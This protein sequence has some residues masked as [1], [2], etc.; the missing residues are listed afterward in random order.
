MFKPFFT[1]AALIA[2]LVLLAACGSVVSEPRTT[3]YVETVSADALSM[4][5]SPNSADIVISPIET[6][7]GLMTAQI[8]HLGDLDYSI[9]GQVSWSINLREEA[10]QN[11]NYVGRPMRWNIALNPAAALDLDV[12]SGSG[13]LTLPLSDFSLRGLRANLG[14]GSVNL[15][16][17]PSETPIPISINGGS[18]SAIVT[19]TDGTRVN[20]DA[21]SLSS[22]DFSFS[23]MG[24]A[25]L[26]GRVTLSSGGVTLNFAPGAAGELNV[27]VASGDVDITFPEGMAVRV[28]LRSMASGDVDMGDALRRLSASGVTENTG[29]WETPGFDE[30]ENQLTLVIEMS[31]GDLRVR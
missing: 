28:D 30:A 25:E 4:S 17:P 14:S 1:R 29:T 23:N 11:V 19:A 21:I 27:S 6:G 12:N 20:F 15:T 31:S 13:D 7:D 3:E 24:Q 10:V 22:G 18:G 5:L 26:A 8:D 2:S 9:T 16:L